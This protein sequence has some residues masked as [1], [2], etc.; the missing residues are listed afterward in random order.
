MSDQPARPSERAVTVLGL[1]AMGSAL[2]AATVAAGHRTT[3]WNRTPGRA[4]ALVE[5]GAREAA[6]VRDAVTAS[7]LVVAV[8]LDHASVHQTL[9][10]V[11]DALAGRA[12]VNLVTTTPEESRELAA[13]AAAHG[14]DYLDGGIMAV[15]GM[16]GGPGA[17]VLYSG[18]RAAFDDARPVLDTWG[19]ST[20]LG[21]DPGLAPLYDLALLASMYAMFAGFFHGVAMV[22][23]AGVSATD[24]ARRA[25]PWLVAMTSGL[26]EYAD[27]VD[28]R[29]YGGPGQQSLAFSDPSDIIRA[30]EEAGLATDVVAAV[31]AL[32]HR[33]IDAG[34][35]ADGFARAV[36]SIRSPVRTPVSD[37]TAG[38]AR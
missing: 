14:I 21:E 33:Q 25:A 12:L 29:D 37:A 9:D 3:V 36:E 5:S 23:T 24:F 6:T 18:S 38:G 15:P 1:G 7:P 35:G 30:S 4:G 20:W 8:V 2:A 13:W 31:Q 32:V 16:I 19:E 11:A 17:E 27:V 22:G 28:R 26:A 10:P 34:H